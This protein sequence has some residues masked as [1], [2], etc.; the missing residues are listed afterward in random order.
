MNQSSPTPPKEKTEPGSTSS[1]ESRRS[2][3][4]LSSDAWNRSA[5]SA[6]SGPKSSNRVVAITRLGICSRIGSENGSADGSPGTG[7]ASI[8]RRSRTSAIDV[9]N[10]PHV[11]RSIQSGIGSRPITPFVGFRPASPQ[12][13]AGILIEPPPSVAVAI[14]AIPAASAAPDPPLDPP[15]D[16]SVPQ[17][18]TVVP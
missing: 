14:A 13:A 11:D 15:G 2:R 4:R 10:G 1:T 16:Q 8:E 12:N 7:P 18:F 17:G 3:S 6:G 9:A 5:T